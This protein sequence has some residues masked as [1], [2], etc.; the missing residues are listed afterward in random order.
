M[1]CPNTEQDYRDNNAATLFTE[2]TAKVSNE[3]LNNPPDANFY[4]FLFDDKTDTSVTEKELIY[5]LHI[6]DGNLK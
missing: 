1:K 6:Y 2:S 3:L 4:L 5:T